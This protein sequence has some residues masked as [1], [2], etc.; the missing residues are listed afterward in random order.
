MSGIVMMLRE[1]LL[2][3]VDPTERCNLACIHCYQRW[4]PRP[5]DLPD[6]EYLARLTELRNRYKP[7]VCIYLGGEPLLRPKLLAE[8]VKLF[9]MNFIVTNGTIGPI[10][11]YGPNALIWVSI[12][13]PRAIQDRIRGRGTYDRIVRNLD[14]YGRPFAV[15]TVLNRLNWPHL[16]EL[17]DE[18]TG[19]GACAFYISLHT[20]Q[21]GRIDELTLVGREREACIREV[22]KAWEGWPDLVVGSP[23]MFKSMLDGNLEGICPL[24]RGILVCYDAAFNRRSPCGM[25][26]NCRVCGLHYAHFLRAVE[27]GDEDAL[28]WAQLLLQGVEK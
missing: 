26:G 17:V 5:P 2:L 27:E 1:G 15:T 11:D 9:P 28:R 22:E 16:V 23:G 24:A 25:M 21:A 7:A 12:D 8:C 18:W 10:P 14:D 13:G 3:Q 20:P 6:G 4:C 19:R